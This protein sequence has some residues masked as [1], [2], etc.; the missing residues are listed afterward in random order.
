MAWELENSRLISTLLLIVLLV[1]F[2]NCGKQ[3]QQEGYVSA[4][5]P[6]ATAAGIA[7]LRA[8]GNA[9]DAA[10]AISFALG[11]TEPAM[12]GLG[13]GTQVLLYLPES[14]EVLALN[15]TFHLRPV[16]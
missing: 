7:I 13:G 4:A 10:I 6:E 15:G 12:S 14:K 3:D 9:A 2:S 16:Q 8:G 5:S 1:G 11:V